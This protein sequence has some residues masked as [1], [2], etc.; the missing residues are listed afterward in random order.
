M[1]ITTIYD[2]IAITHR[3]YPLK[4]LIQSFPQ[5]LGA[6]WMWYNRGNKSS[7]IIEVGNELKKFVIIQDEIMD[8]HTAIASFNRSFL[9]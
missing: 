9:P 5:D 6:D 3:I 8:F 7:P 4:E 2:Y 1:Y